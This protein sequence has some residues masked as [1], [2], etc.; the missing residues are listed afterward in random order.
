VNPLLSARA[1]LPVLA[2]HQPSQSVE[3]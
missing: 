1:E 3:P 2:A